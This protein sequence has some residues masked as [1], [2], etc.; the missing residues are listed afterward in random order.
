M[1]RVNWCEFEQT[2]KR[3]SY[4]HDV[5]AGVNDRLRMFLRGLRYM[6]VCA[7]AYVHR[8]FRQDAG[9]RDLSGV[10]LLH[11]PPPLFLFSAESGPTI[12]LI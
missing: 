12:P 2:S 6:Y 8:G 5:G 3:Q 9:M 11:P 10:L 7:G 4:E 1:V